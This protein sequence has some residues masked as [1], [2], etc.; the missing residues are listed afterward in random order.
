MNSIL[1]RRSVRSLAFLLAVSVAG[2]AEA[3][4]AVLRAL[5]GRVTVRTAHSKKLIIAKPGLR[6]HS[7]DQLRTGPD[8]AAQLV[9]E[10]GATVLVKQKSKLAIK[11]DRLGTLLSF[12]V[13]EFLIGLRRKLKPTESF[14]VRTPAAVAAVRG[15]LFWGLSDAQKMSHYACFTGIVE[16]KAKGHTL[17]LTPGQKVEIPLNHPPKLSGPS[18]I[19][20][21]YMKTFAVDG[22]IQGLDDLLKT[23]AAPK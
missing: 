6:L 20:P 5:K 16:I 15:T 13:G 19:A 22:S 11:G 3:T 10:S 4:E 23:D 8:A 17:T 14:R 21:E 12:D 1:F 18:D 9:F 7:N 2:S